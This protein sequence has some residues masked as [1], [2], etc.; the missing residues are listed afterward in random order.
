MA[1]RIRL[2]SSIT[3]HRPNKAMCPMETRI[4]RMRTHCFPQKL[5]RN[6]SRSYGLSLYNRCLVDNFVSQYLKQSV[7]TSQITR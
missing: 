1:Y 6:A 2:L 7:I 3:K 5:Y 4:D